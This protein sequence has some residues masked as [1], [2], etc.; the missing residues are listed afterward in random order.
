MSRTCTHRAVSWGQRWGALPLSL[1]VGAGLCSALV[2]MALLSWVWTPYPATAI[3]MAARLQGPSASHWLGTDA[4]GRDVASQ[5]LVGARSSLAVG[6][7]A[8]GL[9]L[10]VGAS[11]GLLAAARP[12]WVDALVQ[13]VAD[14]SLAFPALLTAIVLAAVWGPGMGNAVVAIAVFNIP[15]FARLARATALGIWSRDYVLAARAC[16][17]DRW[18]ITWEHVLPNMAAVLIVQASSQFALAILAEAALSYLGLGTQAPQ[19][20]WGRMLSEAQTLLYQ[21]PLLAVFPGVAIALSVLGLNLLGDG[22][23]D[24]IDPRQ[25]PARH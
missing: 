15:I 5:L 2:L 18:R 24:W 8:V 6:L 19:P 14:V 12:G 1:R 10:L 3:D 21:A 16:G 13:R 22:L 20:S 9:G 11:L 7:A 17:K 4:Y 23:R 25:P